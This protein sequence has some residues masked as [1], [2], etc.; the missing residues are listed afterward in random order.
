MKFTAYERYL[1]LSWASAEDTC[2]ADCG[3]KMAEGH[4]VEGQHGHYCSARCKA[5][6]ESGEYED[7]QYE[8]KQMGITS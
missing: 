6:E 1:K 5:T 3:T 7:P 2:E 8:R 4:Y